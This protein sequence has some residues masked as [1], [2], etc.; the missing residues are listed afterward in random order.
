MY[1]SDYRTIKFEHQERID[2]A[3]M[4]RMANQFAGDARASRLSGYRTAM[5]QNV[6]AI[7]SRWRPTRKLNLP[8]VAGSHS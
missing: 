1:L 2:K 4:A 6:A 7:A 3:A 5:A 8:G